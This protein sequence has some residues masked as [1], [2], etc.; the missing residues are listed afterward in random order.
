[1]QS[2]TGFSTV[3]DERMQLWAEFSAIYL[4]APA[5]MALVLP[6]GALFPALFAVTA[7]GLWLLH[8]TRGF[9]WADLKPRR[10]RT[11]WPLVGGFAV[12]TGALVLALVLL[13]EP[14]AFL[15]PGRDNPAL[16]AAILLLYP[17][18]SAL[19]QEIVF[20]PLFFR[21]YGALLP[22]GRAALAVNAAVFSLAHLMYWNWVVAAM[23]FAGGLIFAWAY[24]V[25]RSFALAVLLHSVAGWLIFGLGLGVYFYS[26][27]VE[28]PF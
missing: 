16:L 13:R 8:R 23:T 19:P 11:D 21:R 10:W 17:F 7:V 20:R 18:L 2:N 9:A 4:L 22:R 28:R 26:G 6:P 5:A 12:L 3:R 15:R 14:Q 24:E 1:M 27:N 25:R